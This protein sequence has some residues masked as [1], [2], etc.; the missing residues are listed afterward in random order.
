MCCGMARSERGSY[1]VRVRLEGSN[2]A[3]PNRAEGEPSDNGV[4]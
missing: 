4:V 1:G 2:E 3:I